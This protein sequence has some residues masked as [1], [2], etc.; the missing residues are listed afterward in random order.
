MESKVYWK[1]STKDIDALDLD[2]DE[3]KSP[4]AKLEGNRTNSARKLRSSSKT[5]PPITPSKKQSE[6][7]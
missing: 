4:V 3:I 7:E 2:D 6:S 5:K 1:S